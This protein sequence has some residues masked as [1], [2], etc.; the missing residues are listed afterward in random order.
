M[1]AKTLTLGTLK[2]N[3]RWLINVMQQL[4]LER[5]WS[6]AHVVVI[7][8]VILSLQFVYTYI[9]WFCAWPIMG[10][11]QT[12]DFSSDSSVWRENGSSLS[13]YIGANTQVHHAS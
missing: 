11:D 3:I 12:V 2:R 5:F 13:I 1:K 4:S 10:N 9:Y 8:V 6:D 7:H